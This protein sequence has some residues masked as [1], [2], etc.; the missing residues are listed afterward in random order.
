M[1]YYNDLSDNQFLS[2]SI[3]NEHT[4]RGETFKLKDAKIF[5]CSSL[6][7]YNINLTYIFGF[8]TF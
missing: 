3:K 2:A 8:D 5:F 1:I 7:E 4:I 6:A